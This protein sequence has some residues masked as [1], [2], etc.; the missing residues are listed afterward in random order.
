MTSIPRVKFFVLRKISRLVIN[1]IVKTCRIHITGEEI[2]TDLKH[3]NIPIIYVFW[4]RHIFFTIYR[5]KKTSARPLI[6]HSRDGEIVSQIAEE[7][8]MNPVRGS[9]S[10]G[11]AR[12]FLKLLKS[13][14]TEQSDILITADGPKGPLREI[15]DGTIILARKTNSVIVPFCWYCSRVKIF[16]K[17]W[18]RFILPLPFSHITFSY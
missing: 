11:G 8:G 4:H 13:I 3:K 12:A 9:S 6:S 5:F 17:T 1:A 7:F 18:D 2:I 15:K 14:Q 16:K 10:G